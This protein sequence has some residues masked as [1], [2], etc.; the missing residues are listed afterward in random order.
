MHRAVA[1]VATAAGDLPREH[2]DGIMAARAYI[3]QD[4]AFAG[5]GAGTPL[6]PRMGWD[7]YSA[8][9]VDRVAAA[10]VPMALAASGL[11]RSEDE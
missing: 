3:G 10:V 1:V 7:G 5:A 11:E 2:S 9:R 8:E 4:L 6:L